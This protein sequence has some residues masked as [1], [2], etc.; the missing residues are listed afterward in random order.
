MLFRKTYIN[1]SFFIYNNFNIFQKNTTHP[2]KYK[3][4]Y[5]DLCDILILKI[6]FNYI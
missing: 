1:L 2:L 4:T 3:S 5:S 6:E